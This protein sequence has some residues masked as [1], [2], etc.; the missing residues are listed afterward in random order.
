MPRR[1]AGPTGR[2]PR[3]LLVLAAALLVA[4]VVLGIHENRNPPPRPDLVRWRPAATAEAEARAQGRPLLYDFTAEWCGPCRAMEHQVFAD[5]EGA[6]FINGRFVPVRVQDR[7][8]EEGRNPPL[9]DSLQARFHITGFPTLGV[10]PPQGGEPVTLDGY[11]GKSITLT[12]LAEAAGHAR[13]RRTFR[14]GTT[15]R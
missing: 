10:V 14:L 1:N 9:V 4:R 6:A 5:A 13:P 8:R 3:A 11:A 12:R 7:Q 2:D 15:G